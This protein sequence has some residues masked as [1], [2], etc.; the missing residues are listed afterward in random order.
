MGGLIPMPAAKVRYLLKV[1]S[2]KV[3]N[4]LYAKF[5]EKTIYRAKFAITISVHFAVFLAVNLTFTAKC[6]F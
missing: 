6:A 1:E 4:L 2:C 3:Y 5:L